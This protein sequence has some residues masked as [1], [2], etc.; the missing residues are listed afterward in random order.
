MTTS[1][2]FTWTALVSLVLAA[3]LVRVPILTVGFIQPNLILAVLIAAAFFTNNVAFYALLLALATILGRA[4]SQLFDP[5]IVGI[6]VAAV[7][8]FLIKRHIVWPNRIGVLILAALGTLVTYL[9]A[10]PGFIGGHV[11]AFLFEVAANVVASIILFE[12]FTFTVGR[13]NE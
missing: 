9:I 3:V 10:A 6:V 1:S 7:L 12:V 5:F 8:C 4:T 13:R 11:W 2:R